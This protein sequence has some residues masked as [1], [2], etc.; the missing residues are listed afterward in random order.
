MKL[1]V[2]QAAAAAPSF[3]ARLAAL[4]ARLANS[5]AELVV[6]PELFTTGYHIRADHRELAQEADGAWSRALAAVARR[7]NCAIAYGYAERANDQVYNSAQL[8]GADGS[9]LANHRKQLPAPDCFEEVCFADGPAPTFITYQNIKMALVIC[10]ELEFPETVRHAALHGAT[11]VLAP[12]ALVEEW[13]VIAERLV[14]TRA[15]ESGVWI[16]YANYAGKAVDVQGMMKVFA[17]GSRISAPNGE[18]QVVARAVDELII[19]EIDDA[20]ALKM[21]KRLPYLRDVKRLQ[22]GLGQVLKD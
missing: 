3:E 1:G 20:E 2:F 5:G 17:G 11:L 6:C 14:S 15:I 13:Q 16:A 22:K 12:T 8:I 9:V 10:Y 4:E 19:V 21:R 18:D 7:H